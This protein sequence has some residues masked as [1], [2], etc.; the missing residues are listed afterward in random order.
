V[1]R[2]EA[3]LP[4]SLLGAGLDI[5]VVCE[6][7]EVR[8]GCVARHDGAEGGEPV[9]DTEELGDRSVRLQGD[10]L[11]QVRDIAAGRD[12]SRGGLEFCGDESKQGRFAAAVGADE[13][14]ST[15]C[16]GAGHATEGAFSVGPGEADVGEDDG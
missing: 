11:R 3:D 12:G 9:G 4:Q 5:P 7:I 1:I 13:A 6:C 16:D 8:L 14:G 10:R 15:G 2:V